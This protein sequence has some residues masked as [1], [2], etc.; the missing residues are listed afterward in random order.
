MQ[1]EQAVNYSRLLFAYCLQAL[2]I[3]L[4][5]KETGE[6]GRILLHNAKVYVEKGVYAQAVLTDGGRIVK[7]GTNEE[8]LALKKDGD[9]IRDCGGKTL[10]PGLNDTH[11]HL[12][13][14]AETL[15]QAQIEGTT[16]IDDMIKRC[17]DFALSHP[18]AAEHGIHAMGWNQ[19]LF[20]EGEKR[21]PSRYDLD[22]ISTEYPIVR[23]RI[24]GHI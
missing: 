8:V 3:I 6:M 9:D 15:N 21:I 19:D 13:M 2:F 11:M 23:E 17:R 10:I 20:T 4:K 24:C 18:Q 16:S 22:K 12:F 7:V 1:D 14:F 5:R